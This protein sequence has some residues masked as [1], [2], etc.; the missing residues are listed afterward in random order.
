MV[1]DFEHSGPEFDIMGKKMFLS[2]RFDIPGQEK[3][4]VA[5]RK[6]QHH[7][8]IV[9]AGL[10]EKDRRWM[11]DCHLC[12]LSDADLLTHLGND[13]LDAPLLD[14]LPPR[15]IDIGIVLL[16]AG[17]NPLYIIAPQNLHQTSD[18]IGII[19]S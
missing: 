1:G 15:P 7:R 6:P 19:M 5:V 8:G 2:F 4:E 11:K 13:V 12:R 9:W 3:A 17:Q 14:Q 10:L 16:P 18:V